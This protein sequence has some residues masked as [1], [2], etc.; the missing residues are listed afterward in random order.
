MYARMYVHKQVRTTVLPMFTF[1]ICY[2]EHFTFNAL[3]CVIHQDDMS[4]DLRAGF[5]CSDKRN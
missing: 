4:V 1:G 2:A 3:I 5:S